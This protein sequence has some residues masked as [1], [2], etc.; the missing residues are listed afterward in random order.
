VG[1]GTS[2]AVYRAAHRTTARPAALKLFRHQASDPAWEAAILCAIDHPHIVQVLE[3]GEQEGAPYLA[4]EWL[5]GEDL[6]TRLK[7]EPFSI[8]ATL[9]LVAQI[10]EGLGAAHAAGIVHRD[11][12]PANV[13]LWDRGDGTLHAKILDFGCALRADLSTHADLTVVGTPA[14]MAPEQVRGDHPVGPYSDVF[15]LGAM[16]Y[17]LVV[18]QPPHVASTYFATLARLATTRAPRVSEAKHDIH[19]E[20]DQFIYRMLALTPDERPQSMSEVIRS[21][22]AIAPKIARGS[23]A[24]VEPKSKRLGSS[25]SRLVTTLVASG[26]STPF[27][28]DEALA[29]LKGREALAVP[30][31]QHSLVANFGARRSRGDEA[32]SAVTVGRQLSALGARVGVATGR[33]VTPLVEV[34]SPI[35]PM[36]EVVDRATL[37]SRS[38]EPGQVVVDEAT[39][40]LSSGYQFDETGAGSFAVAAPARIPRLQF[41]S[42]FVGRDQEL[43][44]ILGAFR[45]LATLSHST[46]VSIS[47]APGL[48][49]TRLQREAIRAI[50]SGEQVARLVH[51]RNDPYGQR[52]A[53][54]TALDVVRALLGV[55][56][57][58]GAQAVVRAIMA[59][60][61][62]R[63]GP[64]LRSRVE[65]LASLLSSQQIPPGAETGT[66]RDVLWLMMTIVVES[67]LVMG[68]V[69]IVSED[70]QWA[71]PESIKWFEHLLSR[72]SGQPLLLLLTA[73]PEFWA[74]HPNSFA[75]V[76]HVRI[77]LHPI[78]DAATKSI[79]ESIARE[80]L[81]PEALTRIVEQAAG[82]PLFAEELSRLAA[83]GT[84]VSVAPTIEAAIQVSLDALTEV[85]SDAIGRLSVLGSTVWDE[86]LPALGITEAKTV[87]EELS[88]LETLV[89]HPGS[90]FAN[91][92]ER[93]FKHALVRDVAYNRLGEEQRREL[94]ARAAE[95]LERMG[96]DAAIVARHFDLAQRPERAAHHW[97]VAAERALGTNALHVAQ[98]MA[99]RALTFSTDKK[100]SFQRA[101][102]LDEIWLRLDARA[103]DRETAVCA[104]EE[105]VY[106]AESAVYAEGAR[107][108]FDAVRGHGVDVDARLAQVRDRAGLLGLYD[109][110]ARTGA[111]LAT[112]LAF[113]GQFAAAQAEAARLLSLAESR[114]IR[115]A[116][117]DAW[118]TL[119]I[120]H[121]SLGELG[122][123]L[124]A[125]R[126]AARAA[127]EAELRERE[128][129]LVTNLGF[130]LTTFGAP[131]EAR[132][133][134]EEGLRLALAIGSAGARRHALMLMLC[135]AG[136]FGTDPKLDEILGEIRAHADESAAGMW[137]PPARENLGMLYYRGIDLLHTAA[138][139]E[140]ASTPPSR[141]PIPKNAERAR[142]LLQMAARAYRTTGNRDVLPVALGLWGRAELTCGN[143][144]TAL[145]L[146]EEAAQLL[147]GGAPSLLNE[148]PVFLSLHDALVATG[149]LPA[150]CT[151][152]ARALPYLTRR[153][154]GLAGTRYQRTFLA[155]L[156]DNARL[157]TLARDFGI[158]PPELDVPATQR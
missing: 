156:G 151:S 145:Q 122:R 158:C 133:M 11:V 139:P 89:E 119:A 12:K 93:Q 91:M 2:G 74:T 30:L 78:S 85:Q 105:G 65:V 131:L 68:P 38:A 20:L 97:A 44:Q 5:D 84:N 66:I 52:R 58:D 59:Q 53:L 99:E 88:E 62:A 146:A 47:G 155:D 136:T 148:A 106:D 141:H 33:V 100:E 92:R 9:R 81:M 142:I 109:E 107:A 26:F 34:E 7:R 125:R 48:G 77:E 152:I 13:M 98:R 73:R 116:A 72:V 39:R 69:V 140:R 23:I 27:L 60:T 96:E 113:A 90:R 28:R 19:P 87:L 4:M 111:E 132:H 42:R 25:A 10:A 82:S 150:A 135:W 76:P 46:L 8:Q 22:E 138:P 37:L 79:V 115:A 64:D 95:W 63:L 94:H 3:A 114:G 36:G 112:R 40:S 83:A 143:V 56:K 35:Q 103:S 49:K 16:L 55:S 128:S 1:S 108:R 126:S 21:L 124:D 102:M 123:A 24:D 50:E 134:L 121:Q 15:S 61:G 127:R 153:V 154:T 120:V 31:G 29:E 157:V 104:M 118:Q 51:Q 14:Y 54:G 45:S 80:P 57:Q 110:E 75:T 70:A 117:V 149:D 144:A 71:D 101:R 147:D 17:E 130:A 137:T 67:S 18:G 32:T 6:Q 41:E 86:A 129:V 43:A